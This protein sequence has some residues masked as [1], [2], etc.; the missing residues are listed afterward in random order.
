MTKEFDEGAKVSIVEA[1]RTCERCHEDERIEG[2]AMIERRMK[3]ENTT[4][5]AC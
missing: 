2:A 3:T 5:S 1:E 4:I